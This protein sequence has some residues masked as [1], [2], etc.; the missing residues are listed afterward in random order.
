VVD[1]P[2]TGKP[3]V[4]P[5]LWNYNGV[6]YNG[7]A[8]DKALDILLHGVQQRLYQEFINQVK[9]WGICSS[10]CPLSDGVEYKPEPIPPTVSPGVAASCDCGKKKQGTKIINGQQTQVN[11]Y[12]WMVGVGSKGS[13]SPFC[14]GALVSDQYVLTAA[15][16]TAGKQPN[17]IQVSIGDHDWTQSGDADSFRMA[18]VQI[19]QHPS[20]V[21]G[22]NLANDAALI[23]FASQVNFGA[24]SHVRP[25]CFC[26]S[27]VVIGMKTS[28]HK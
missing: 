17:E 21:G 26:L 28:Q 8:F 23:K 6:N 14:G 12:P 1:G 2:G 15:H 11:E 9:E 25:V 19:K 27:T 10:S 18:V 22:N 5:F 4:F 16:C 7:C 13:M 3:C 24:N 20:Y